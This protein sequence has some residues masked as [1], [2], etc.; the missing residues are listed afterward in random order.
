MSEGS[1]IDTRNDS[2]STEDDP[3]DDN[4]TT[5]AYNLRNRGNVNYMSMYK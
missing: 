4:P 1:E 3:R 2:E 5:H